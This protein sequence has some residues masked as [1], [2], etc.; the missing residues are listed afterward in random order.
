MINYFSNSLRSEKKNLF[1]WQPSN[2]SI[3]AGDELSRMIVNRVLDLEMMSLSSVTCRKKLFAIGSV[4][5]FARTGDCIWGTGVNGKVPLDKHIYT[6]LDVRAVRG[7]LTRQFLMQR[8]IQVPE[9]YGD[10][11]ILAPLFYPK[12]LFDTYPSDTLPPTPIIIP[13][14]NEP[15]TLA[16][17]FTNCKVV[18]AMQT[19]VEF[20]HDIISSSLVVSSSLHGIVLAE[21]YGIPAHLVMPKSDETEF[22][23]SDYYLGTGRENFRI[24][25]SYEDAL[26][27]EVISP[28]DFTLF[29]RK[30]LKNFPWDNFKSSY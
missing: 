17:S 3:N 24:F 26:E 18:S 19:P 1:W 12:A 5:H 20:I 27:A 2:G 9:V 30:L 16:D 6:D 13:H 11:G 29:Q 8:G 28:P 4:L 21:A 14:M 7:P 10:P 23:Y 15:S 22:K 25:Q